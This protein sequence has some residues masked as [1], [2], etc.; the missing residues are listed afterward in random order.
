M[1]AL[2][3]GG[4][5]FLGQAIVRKLIARGEQV[6]TLCRS[7]YPAL[8]VPGVTQVRGD[9]ADPQTVATAAQGV[10]VI[11]HVAA[12]AGMW[13]RRADYERTNVQGTANVVDASRVQG[14]SRL[15]YTSSPSVVHGREDLEGIDESQ[16]Y[17]DRYEAHY[18]ATKAAAER[19]VLEADCASLSTVALRP[20]LIWGPGDNHLAPR[21]VARARA[22]RLRL[23]G[24][25]KNLIDTV[26]VENAAD[27]HL[28]AADRL[29]PDAPCAGKAYFISQGDPR[30]TREIINGIVKAAGLPSVEATIP[31]PIAY[32]LG[33]ILEG[34]HR[35]F[36]PHKEPV[37]TRFLA[38]NLAL[39]HWYD[40]S[41][42]RRDLGYEPAVSIDEGMELLRQWFQG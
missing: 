32:A 29:G 22:G 37:M 10:D 34:A 7:H 33:A 3:T 35:A 39:A 25:G 30:P 41:A 4:G 15:V 38:R 12:R 19:L 20:H 14:V 28:L 5:G 16:P 23:V 31:Y 26:Y 36:A 42:A 11:F 21:I 8:D 17:P 18:P 9:I 6:V 24:S 1:R 27:A 13:G 40:M 2:V